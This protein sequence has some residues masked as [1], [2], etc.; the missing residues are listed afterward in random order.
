MIFAL[1]TFVPHR[2]EAMSAAARLELYE[3]TAPKY[4][5]IPGLLRKYYIGEPG[6]RAGGA[7]E[8]ETMAAAKAYFTP[9]WEQF[10]IVNYGSDLRVEYFDAPCVV[11]NT[12]NLI[13]IAPD[14]KASAKQQAAE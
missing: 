11:D 14:V 4:Q 10:M 1:V 8:F 6:K 7:Y 12:Q 3:R 2:K 13:T 9:A 5:K